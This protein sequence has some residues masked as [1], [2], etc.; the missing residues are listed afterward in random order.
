MADTNIYIGAWLDYSRQAANRWT[1]TTTSSSGQILIAAAAIMIQMT[2]AAMW[3]IVSFWLHQHRA[4]ENPRHEMAA[5]EA[6]VL[7]NSSIEAAVIH[8]WNLGKRWHKRVPRAHLRALK[9]LALPLLI[10]LSFIAA[11]ILSSH[12]AYLQQDSHVLAVPT[13]CGFPENLTFWDT[14]ANDADQVIAGRAYARD[15]YTL[16]KRTVDCSGIWQKDR[17]PYHII[18][19][20]PCPISSEYCSLGDKGAVTFWSLLDSHD[21]LGINALPNDRIQIGS[22][23]T[24]APLKY[25]LLESYARPEP[26]S[27]TSINGTTYGSLVFQVTNT[28]D[29]TIEYNNISTFTNP[30]YAANYL[31]PKYLADELAG[32]APRALLP[33]FVMGNIDIVMIFIVP[34]SIVY[35][36][37]SSDPVFGTYQ[38]SF[39]G[40]VET[41]YGDLPY[42]RPLHQ[43]NGIACWESYAICNA[44]KSKCTDWVAYNS[45]LVA[46]NA[47]LASIYGDVLQPLE[48]NKRQNASAYR[49]LSTMN[50]LPLPIPLF[51]RP[52]LYASEDVFLYS[53]SD[54]LPNDQWSTEVMLWYETALA[55]I[56]IALHAFINPTLSSEVGS[57]ETPELKEQ[58]YLQR[59]KLPTGYQNFSILGILLLFIFGALLTT[60]AIFLG[61]WNHRLPDRQPGKAKHYKALAW[62]SDGLLQVHRRALEGLGI[63]GWKE[64]EIPYDGG[65]VPIVH[66]ASKRIPPSHDQGVTDRTGVQ[67]T[68]SQRRYMVDLDLS[69]VEPIRLE[70]E[71]VRGRDRAAQFTF[72]DGHVNSN[73]KFDTDRLLR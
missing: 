42:Y 21:D 71:R 35:A 41:W 56:P 45:L 17:L 22:N 54:G 64:D 50:M 58:C 67:K 27:F 68:G 61:I 4:T 51:A 28:S 6:I 47:Q 48:L 25:E 30:N 49:T 39:P 18:R 46:F 13:K 63:D 1:L 36:A 7:R 69:N 40:D 59:R 26:D 73:W 12:I 3:L 66:Q 70:S 57:P 9:I 19:D 29:G 32:S 15:C 38:S 11:A 34:N 8:A 5:Q 55:T 14:Y 62:W 10:K 24:C 52:Q 60:V 33:P 44:A 65:P 31:Y 16:S 37:P 23:L 53:L 2:G 20:A 72:D 43:V